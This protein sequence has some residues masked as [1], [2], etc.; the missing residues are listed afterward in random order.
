MDHGLAL[1]TPWY[2]C[3]RGGF[4]RF[5]PR[6][7]APRSRNTT[8]PTWSSG[9][10]PI[11]ATRSS[12]PGTGRLAVPGPGGR[13]RPGRRPAALRD[14]PVRRHR[15]AQA[16]PA[17]PRPVLRRRGRA[18]LRRPRPAPA[19]SR[20]RRGAGAGDAAPV[21]RDQ[22]HG[23]QSPP[24]RPRP[25]QDPRHGPAQGDQAGPAGRRRRPG[26]LCQARPPPPA[27]EKHLES[28]AGLGVSLG[29]RAG[30]SAAPAAAG[31]GSAAPATGDGRGRAGAAD[32]ADP[33]A[34][35]TARR[36]RPGR[37]GSGWSRRSRATTTAP[38]GPSSTTRRSTS[39]AASPGASRRPAART[40]RRR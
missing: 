4:D 33:R 31:A 17:E 3:E 40:A 25:D 21:A 12:S 24:G 1:R 11:R 19:G 30:W 26:P 39:C 8:P 35:R 14:P 7:Q 29:S 38:A 28:L 15:P 22:G 2:V 32:V 6:A 37:C 23:H 34:P 36:R 20:G 18:V 16:L 27:P 5:D 13:G 10:W 9:C